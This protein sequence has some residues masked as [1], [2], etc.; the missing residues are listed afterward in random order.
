AKEKGV[1]F[2]DV[3]EPPRLT[4]STTTLQP[5]PTIDPKDKGKGVLMEEELEKLE[6][7]KRSDQ[8]L[9][10]I[11]SDA[12]LAQRIYE[13]ELAELDKAQKER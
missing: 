11:E 8:G 6:K 3:K 4:R 2:R 1:A 12:E 13:E 9:A 5:L 10:Q 7:V